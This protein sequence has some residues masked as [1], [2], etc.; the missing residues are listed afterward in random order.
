MTKF[1]ELDTARKV[2]ELDKSADMASIK[3]NYRRLLSEWHPDRNIHKREE[4]HK[5][6][7]EIVGA[8]QTITQY[9]QEYRY[10]FTE[11]AVRRHLSPEQ[12]WAERFGVDPLW[13]NK[14]QDK[15]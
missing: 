10:S 14:N 15:G 2:L 12:W 13:S 9:C 4:C 7:Q 3:S 6:T 5:K 8:Y 1:Q 11:D